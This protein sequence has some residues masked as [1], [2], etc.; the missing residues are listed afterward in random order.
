MI[1]LFFFTFKSKALLISTVGPIWEFLKVP[2]NMDLEL[3]PYYGSWLTTGWVLSPWLTKSVK[4]MQGLLNHPVNLQEPWILRHFLPLNF[5]P[6]L[7]SFTWK[8]MIYC[9][10]R[11]SFVGLDKKNIFIRYMFSWLFLY[12]LQILWQ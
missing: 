10:P 2:H 6:K 12:F 5:F 8:K 7:R 1:C 9:L 4:K 11:C 3:D